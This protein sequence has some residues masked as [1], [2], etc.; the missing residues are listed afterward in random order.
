MS[1]EEQ[2]ASATREITAGNKEEIIG[3]LYG[4]K[5]VYGKRFPKFIDSLLVGKYERYIKQPSERQL[6]EGLSKWAQEHPEDAKAVL[7]MDRAPVV[8][9]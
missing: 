9:K 7:T 3:F 8:G 2:M 5:L 1:I 4:A 6:V